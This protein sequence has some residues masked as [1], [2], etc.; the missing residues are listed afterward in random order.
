MRPLAVAAGACLLACTSISTAPELA[1][2]VDPNTCLAGVP[3]P[4]PK[5]KDV[6]PEDAGVGV[7]VIVFDAGI[8]QGTL[9]EAGAGPGISGATGPGSSG[10]LGP[11]CPALAPTNGAPCDTIANSLPC[12]YARIT[13]FCVESWTCF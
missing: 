11:V 8:P 3:V 7:D 9:P 13:C 4:A 5:G 1:D 6:T 2:C 10:E 12:A